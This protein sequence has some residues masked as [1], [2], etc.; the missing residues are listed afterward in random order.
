MSNSGLEVSAELREG[1]GVT[2]A[3]DREQPTLDTATEI[4]TATQAKWG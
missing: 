3:S 2:G 4:A 1:G